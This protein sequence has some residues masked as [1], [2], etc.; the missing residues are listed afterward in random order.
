VA[1]AARLKAD[2][3]GV[4]NLDCAGPGFPVQAFDF[5]VCRLHI[6]NT[7]LLH[8]S[9]VRSCLASLEA[10]NRIQPE[11]LA[12]YAIT[13]SPIV[14]KPPLSWKKT[15]PLTMNK[16]PLEERI[17]FA[18]RLERIMKIRNVSSKELCAATGLNDRSLRNY[19]RGIQYPLLDTLVAIAKAVNLSVEQLENPAAFSDVMLRLAMDFDKL[20]FDQVCVVLREADNYLLKVVRSLSLKD[21]DVI[22]R[23]YDDLLTGELARK[24]LDIPAFLNRIHNPKFIKRLLGTL[25]TEPPLVI[26]VGKDFEKI[27]FMY[28]GSIVL[29]IPDPKLLW[30][31]CCRGGAEKSPECRIHG[32]TMGSLVSRLFKNGLVRI[33]WRGGKYLWRWSPELWPPSVDTFFLMECMERTGVM[34]A[35]IKSVLDVGSGTGFLGIALAKLNRNIRTVVLSDWL[36]TPALFGQ[37]NWRM[38]AAP[39]DTTVVTSRVAMYTEPANTSDGRFDLVA[40]NPPYLPSLAGCEDMGLESTVFGTDLLEH[41]IQRAKTLGQRVFIQYSHLAHV[42]ASRAADSVEVKLSKLGSKRDVPFRVRHA[43]DHPKYVQALVQ[44]RKLQR[45]KQRRGHRYFHELRTCKVV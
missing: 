16:E 45:S 13:T 6:C 37:I 11:Q 24:G 41:V 17:A 44:E 20:T 3:P 28:N 32:H 27:D 42:E 12:H 22:K 9:G 4:V 31:C 14:A 39:N 34:T 36:L 25:P 43:L 29:S 10:R 1:L 2:N 5:L 18:E 26:S 38:N 21:Y 33:E 30:D 15:E 8:L 40:C 7:A 23:G 35:N 19:R